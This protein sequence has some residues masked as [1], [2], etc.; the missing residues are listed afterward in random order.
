M[1]NK[2]VGEHSLHT[3]SLLNLSEGCQALG[4]TICYTLTTIPKNLQNQMITLN[5]SKNFVY[6]MSIFYGFILIK[7]VARWIIR[8]QS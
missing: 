2:V 8:P 5:F 7:K 4:Q 1:W 3:F 6:D